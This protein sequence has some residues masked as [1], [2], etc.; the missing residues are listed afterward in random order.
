MS[1]YMYLDDIRN[2]TTDRNWNVVR[3]HCEAVDMILEFGMPAYISFDH[4]L[5]AADALTGYDLAKW[6]VKQDMDGAFKIAP[7]F[8]FNVHSANPVGAA[9]ITL[10]LNSYMKLVKEAL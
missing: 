9:N 6:I 3:S 4:D 8:K 1:Y 7:S 2:P 10:Y 5:G